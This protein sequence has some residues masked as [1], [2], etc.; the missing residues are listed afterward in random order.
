M[1]YICR[2]T[3]YNRPDY[4]MLSRDNELFD[5]FRRRVQY[6]YPYNE[7]YHYQFSEFKEIEMYS[8]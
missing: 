4:S 2:I 3:S 8:C 7:D 5:D 1:K 6:V